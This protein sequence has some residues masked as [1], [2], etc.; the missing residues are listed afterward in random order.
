MAFNFPLKFPF[1]DDSSPQAEENPTQEEKQESE[2]LLSGWPFV[3]YG[4][5]RYKAASALVLPRPKYTWFAE[6]DVN[7][8]YI[9]SGRVSTNLR[10]FLQ[11]N[12]N[13]IYVNLKRMDHPKPNMTFDTLRSHN[14]YVK[15]PTKVE[16]PPAQMTLDDDST[17]IIV[18]MWKEYFAFYSHVGDVGFENL[19]TSTNLVSADEDNNFAFDQN[20]G[21]HGYGHL[22]SSEGTEPRSS[23]D[24]R[25]SMGMRLKANQHRHFFDR[26][27]LYDLGTEPS[28]VNVYY[29]YRPV[30]TS[31]D[32]ADVDWEDRSGKVEANVTFEYEN[33][34]FALGMETSAVADIIERVTG[35]R[36]SRTVGLTTASPNSHGHMVTPQFP[37]IPPVADNSV[38][39]PKPVLIGNQPPT[40]DEPPGI[41]PRTPPE[42]QEDI[43]RSRRGFGSTWSE[44]CL[45]AS[46]QQIC[47]DAQKK[48]D[49]DLD[50]YGE[51]LEISQAYYAR[52]EA[53]A[54]NNLSTRDAQNNTEQANGITTNTPGITDVV[55]TTPQINNLRSQRN[56]VQGSRNK[57][58]NT[59][60]QLA[61]QQAILEA[62]LLAS[63][64]GELAGEGYDFSTFDPLQRDKVEEKLR[65]VNQQIVDTTRQLQLIDNRLAQLDQAI[66]NVT[67]A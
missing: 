50:F 16:Y 30:I 60:S 39:G 47:R 7:Q 9:D 14:K 49:E 1:L 21:S 67:T 44:Y 62:E 45:S 12:H 26:I 55:R 53:E 56:Q 46:D 5:Q 28:S 66:Q 11:N 25:A 40:F 20:M 37:D 54:R 33:Y 32:H 29:Y 52:Q 42:I 63:D 18:A 17:S 65:V 64:D 3:N 58:I 51:E 31:F 35:V 57:V 13:R 27:V 10:T 48:L 15:V 41:P 22:V 61:A 6:F 38:E 24:I 19:L 43:N 23:M 8:D 2:G 4:E 36:P 59:R 34:Y